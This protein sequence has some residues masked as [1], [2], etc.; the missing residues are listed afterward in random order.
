[1]KE[2]KRDILLDVMKGVGILLVVFGHTHKGIVGEAMGLFRMPMFLMLS[3]AAL[4]YASRFSLK[5]KFKGLIVPYLTFSIVTFIYWAFVEARFRPLHDDPIFTGWLGTLDIKIQQFLNIFTAIG[6]SN[7]FSYNVVLWF[8]PCLFV[9]SLIYEGS[10]RIGGNS[11]VKAWIWKA[12]VSIVCIAAFVIIDCYD[13]RL[14]WCGELALL[15]VPFL[16]I[17][18]VG[19]PRMR[20]VMERSKLLTILNGGGSLVLF[21]LLYLWLEPKT[22]MNSHQI[23]ALWIFYVMAVLGSVFVMAM[24]RFI[25]YRDHGWMQ[26]CGKH[27][28]IIMCVHEPIKRILIQVMSMA[29]GMETT[30]LRQ[31]LFLSVLIVILIAFICI[32]IIN[33]VNNYLPFMIGKKK[34][35]QI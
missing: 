19:Y 16:L 6:A 23:P 10:K 22:D 7:A 34:P 25:E 2:K 35:S 5:K 24:C 15:S 17:G 32:P 13:I 8:L 27:S 3:G 12:V 11:E 30:A 4:V 29:T 28:L 1:M 18:E 21:I 33:V 14:P 31:N 26:Y 20:A 9:A